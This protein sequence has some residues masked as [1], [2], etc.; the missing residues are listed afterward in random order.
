MIFTVN[1]TGSTLSPLEFRYDLIDTENVILD[2]FE[3]EDETGTI[4]AGQSSLVLPALTTQTAATSYTAAGVTLRLRTTSEY[5]AA[6]YRVADP[7]S[8]KVGVSST[9]KPE[10]T[11]SIAPNYILEGDSFDLVASATPHPVRPITIDVNLYSDLSDGFLVSESRGPQTITI[12]ANQ[13]TGSISITSQ[14]DGTADNSGI[15]TAELETGDDYTRPADPDDQS[16]TVGVLESYP[17]VSISTPSQ[18]Q[19]RM[20]ARSILL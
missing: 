17:V 4:L 6:T 8:L 12:P 10:I 9:A 18:I 19:R 2:T 5:T 3:V 14:A 20:M 7:G 1:R 16:T 15:I 13:R 11:L